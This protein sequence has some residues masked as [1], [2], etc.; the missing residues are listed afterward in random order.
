MFAPWSL[1]PGCDTF[2]R[3]HHSPEFNIVTSP[4]PQ[5]P[6]LHR[7]D[8]LDKA[9]PLSTSLPSHNNLCRPTPLSLEFASPHPLVAQSHAVASPLTMVSSPCRPP[10][11]RQHRTIEDAIIRCDGT[12]QV[13]R[14]TYSCPCP[15]DL[16][17]PC[18]CTWSLDKFGIYILYLAQERFTRHADITTHRRYEYAE[19]VTITL[20]YIK[21]W[22]E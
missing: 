8:S 21:V 10:V 6:T 17:Q 9:L 14:P 5:H 11:P 4:E 3:H 18:R 12:F 15:T 1:K 20:F 2:I 13:I 22:K 16:R 19:V 7:A